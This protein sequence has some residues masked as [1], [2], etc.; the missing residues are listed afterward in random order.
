MTISFTPSLAEFRE[1][2]TRGNL[3]PVHTELIAD[4][5]S[6]VSAFQKIDD[7]GYSFLFESV[8]KSDQVGRYSFVGANPRLIFESRG[9][10][11]RITENGATREFETTRDP[12]SE[13]ETLMQRYTLVPSLAV[14]ESRF[15]GGAVGYLGYDM[16]RFFEPTVAPSPPDD[17]GLPESLFIITETQLIFDH[18]TRRLRVVAN[19][20]VEGDADAAYARAVGQIEAIVAKLAQPTNLPPLPITPAPE[21]PAPVGN[22]KREEYMRMVSDGQEFIRAGDIFQFV[23][24]QRFATDYDGDALTL[25]RALR[26][27]NPSP[28]MFVLKFAGQFSIVGSSPEVHVRAID[29]KI[30]IRPIAGTRKRGANAEQDEANAADLLADPK[31]CAEH[32]MLVDLARNDVGRAS[33][34]GSVKVTDFMTIEK[35]S[36]VMHIVS[37]VEGR[38]RPDRNAYDVMR[39]TFPAGTVSGSPKVRALQIINSLEKNKRGVYAGAVGYFG[40]DGNSDSCIALRTVVLKDG[41]AYVQAGAGVVADS[42]PDGEHQECVNKAM[43]MMAAIARAKTF[44]QPR[45]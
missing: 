9:R 41:Q 22:T 13:L 8:E 16:V 27:V 37:N 38:L 12:L 17:L 35:Y 14:A 6:P 24:S 11:I 18:R 40:F 1:L 43:G 32:L 3:I 29:G 25:Y 23:P 20:L 10:A 39:A 21:V 15:V 26:F 28:Y 33:E 2:A 5:E 42:T 34:F 31:E 7:G 30:E 44:S 36:H 4:A 19:A 45:N